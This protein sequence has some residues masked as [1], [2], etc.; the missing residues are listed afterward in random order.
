MAGTALLMAGGRGERMAPFSRLPK[1]LVPVAGVPLLVRNLTALL[2]YG[3]TDLHVA[4]PAGADLLR[5]FLTDHCSPFVRRHGARLSL[6][7]EPLPLGTLGA[8]AELC[9]RCDALLVVNADNLTSLDLSVLLRHHL[10]PPA[11]AMTLAVHTQPIPVPWGQIEMVAGRV[12]AY[13]EKPHLPVPICSGCYVL[14]PE[15]MAALRVG[16]RC[17]APDLVR[18][19]VA[20]GMD[21]RA[22]EHS[23]RWVDVNDGAAVARATTMVLEHPEDFPGPEGLL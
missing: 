5:G 18:A 17:D 19:L 12:V 4:I 20:S 14:G 8:A 22:C 16:Q 3:L 6:I 11:A 23:A 13:R 21:V 15:A 7:V 1:P 9:G 10:G 2:R